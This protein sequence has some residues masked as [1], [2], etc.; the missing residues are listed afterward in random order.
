MLPDTDMVRGYNSYF[1]TGL[2]SERY[3]SPNPA[4]LRV[5]LDVVGP[6]PARVLDFGCG[7]GRYAVPLLDRTRA[8]I[9]AYDVSDAA[10]AEMS[11]RCAP[12]I[13]S[14]RLRMCG[15]GLPDLVRTMDGEPGF[16]VA[17]M[18][19]G[20]LGH[21][22]TRARRIET[23]RTVCMLLRP[24]GRLVA[25]VPNIRRRFPGARREA[26]SLVAAGRLE[27][28][29]I[30]YSRRSGAEAI[31][32]YYHLYTRREFTEDLETAGFRVSSM[33][34]ESIL[35]E[36]GIVSTPGLGF[37]DAV[38][39]RLVPLDLAYGLLAVAQVRTP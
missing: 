14:G 34:A 33:R 15:G 32:L 24:G 19:F 17:I 22:R 27:P 26:R 6:H 39:A 30:L 25:S 16:D 37:L 8:C 1:G 31:D 20:V 18:M 35:P 12:H 3:P 21:V 28:G 13:A 7:N 23:L 29:D 5:L 11:S 10:L 9:V 38:L 4:S 36:S 2:Y